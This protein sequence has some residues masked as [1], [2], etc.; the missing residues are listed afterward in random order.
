MR[1]QAAW[2][3]GNDRRWLGRIGSPGR[4]LLAR[5]RPMEQRTPRR[6]S[7]GSRHV[8]A[9]RDVASRS[10]LR[11]A[12]DDRAALYV[13]GHVPWP[14]SKG[15]L[16]RALRRRLARTQSARGRRGSRGSP[17]GRGSCPHRL[18]ILRSPDACA[19]AMRARNDPSTVAARCRGALV[20][21]SPPTRM[22]S[23]SSTSF[24]RAA[25]RPRTRATYLFADGAL[26]ADGDRPAR[27]PTDRRAKAK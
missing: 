5:Q 9:L 4:A 21:P 14:G 22:P 15:P 2:A 25:L 24:P 1:A 8:R 10:L 13:R 20:V 7:G 23:A 17:R 18:R 6:P 11:V 27:S 16:G 3:L 19:R 12:L 26:L